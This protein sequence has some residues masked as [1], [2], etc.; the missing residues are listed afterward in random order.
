M[1]TTNDYLAV[2]LEAHEMN[3]YR[4]LFANSYVSDVL[5]PLMMCGIAYDMIDRGLY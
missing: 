5:T 1:K 3:V 2:I 4:M